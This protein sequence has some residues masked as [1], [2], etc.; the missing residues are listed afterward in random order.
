MT[1][2]D[3]SILPIGTHKGKTLDKVPDHWF[4]WF[5]G[6]N[7]TAYLAGEL[8]GNNL[9]IMDYINDNLDVLKIKL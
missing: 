5:W 4:V 6:E 2:N 3:N 9:D 7:K 1:L 8:K